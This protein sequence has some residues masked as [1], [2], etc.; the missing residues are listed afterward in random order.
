VTGPAWLAGCFAVLMIA[1]AAYA[2]S[3][4]V[5]SLLRGR[6]TERTTDGLHVLMGVAM[7]GMF[8]PQIAPVPGIVW[9]V[10]F[11]VGAAW[12][13]WQAGPAGRRA[14]RARCAHP[15]PHAIECAVMVYMLA[16]VGSCRQV[17]AR[18]CRC[19]ARARA[20]PQATRR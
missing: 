15:V 19:R 4:V 9:R 6:D 2:A 8:Q 16:P 14:G 3:R 5:I 18:R 12:F 20:R 17:T 11:A 1:V 13:A 7:A 10:V